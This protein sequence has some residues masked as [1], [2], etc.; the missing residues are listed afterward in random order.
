MA[1]RNTAAFGIYRSR[2]HAEQAVDTLLEDGFRSEDI[3]VLMPGG[4][5]VSVHCD[6]T[7]W[8]KRAKN[9][10]ERTGASD[11]T[12]AGEADADSA[13]SDKPRVRHGGGEANS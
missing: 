1:G 5:L 9:I 7:D 10:M 8:V 3:S 11:I 6:N 12:S 4:V 13:E 2:T